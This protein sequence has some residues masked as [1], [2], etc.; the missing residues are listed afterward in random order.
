MIQYLS[1]TEID[2]ILWDRCIDQSDQAIVYANSWYLDIVSPGWSALVDDNY[3]AV[4]P[5]TWRKK[6][7]FNYLFQPAFTQQLGLFSTK[8]LEENSL[9]NFLQAIPL[10]F[11]LIEIQLNCGNNNLL[12]PAGFNKHP[13]ITHQLNLGYTSS[14]LEKKFSENTKRN[15]KKFEKSSILVKT[16]IEVAD[17]VDLFRK[18]RGKKISQL[19]EEDYSVF[20][21]ICTEAKKRKLL[22]CFGAVDENG[23]LLAGTIFL[24]SHFGYILL[25]TALSEEGKE[26]GA[27]S[28]LISNFIKE[29]G[30]EKGILDFEGSMDSGLARFYKSF[31]SHEIV[32]L[33]IRN[34]RLPV[35]LRWL[36]N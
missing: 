18:N 30:G 26:T 1:H 36:K 32:Y 13:R 23:M 2:K 35:F 15:T 28:T 9:S 19:R 4:F 7:S 24:R 8:Q 6:W 16:N 25:F 17:I 22:S 34:N 5:I 20:L 12:L 31:G 21:S 10:T 27:M 3:R 29:H 11:K 33:Q 14:E